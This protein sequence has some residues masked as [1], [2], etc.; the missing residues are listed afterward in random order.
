MTAKHSLP[1]RVSPPR[2][3]LLIATAVLT[4]MR[5]CTLATTLPSLAYVTSSA[6]SGG[7]G[8]HVANNHNGLSVPNTPARTGTQT[9]TPTA[10]PASRGG[11]ASQ[12]GLIGTWKDHGGWED[13]DGTTTITFNDADTLT[14]QSSCYV[15]GT[16]HLLGSDQLTLTATSTTCGSNG[17]VVGHSYDALYRIVNAD[18]LYLV[19]EDVRAQGVPDTL[20]P[21]SRISGAAD[22]VGEWRKLHPNNSPPHELHYHDDTFTADGVFHDKVIDYVD[23]SVWDWAE[24]TYSLSGDGLLTLDITS[25]IDPEYDVFQPGLYDG[26]YF[27]DSSGQYMNMTF[28]YYDRQ[29]VPAC[30]GDCDGNGQVTVNEILLMVN[31]ALDNGGSC[32]SG[33]ADGITPDVS[34]ILRA[35]NNALNGCAA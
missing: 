4:L 14:F 22:I 12:S 6:S 5:V 21:Y 10:L 30:I 28:A 35:V 23:N 26:M 11:A 3:P 34:L 18:R 16:Y 2:C 20:Y 8:I 33:V 29:S 32:P 7:G 31:M 17:P 1:S 25:V 27:I 19:L 9:P 15:A 24:G 13:H